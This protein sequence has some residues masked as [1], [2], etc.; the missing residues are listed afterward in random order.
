MFVPFAAENHHIL[1]NYPKVYSAYLN[2]RRTK[3][4]SLRALEFE[5][6]QEENLI[7]LI[8]EL[9][10]G[11][12]Q[13]STS[14]CFYTRK[15]KYREIFAAAFRDRIVHHLVYNEIAPVWEKIFIH[16]SY[17]C[18]PQKG[19]HAA[20]L[21]LQKFI[22]QATEN[23][24]KRCYYL[25]LDIKN[26]FMTINHQRL[27][28]ILAGKCKNHDLLKLLKLIVF[29][30]PTKNFELQDRE[31]IKQFIPEH[32]SLF[33]NKSGSGLPIGNLTS[34]FFAN[35]YLNVLDQF[36]KHKLKC[37]FY[38]RY[39]D[40]FL[41]IDRNS[42]KL[43]DWYICV[44]EFLKENLDLLLN[45]KATRLAPVSGG[46]DFVGFIVRKD[47]LLV[48][49]R[50]IG[51]LK[52]KLKDAENKL[53][54]RSGDKTLFY[55]N[56]EVI[57]HLLAAINSYL[58]HFRYAK[59][60][61]CIN[62][63]FEEFSFL[64]TYYLLNSQKI[65]RIDHLLYRVR[66]FKNQ[67]YWLNSKFNQYICLIEIGSYYEAFNRN[68]LLLSKL[69]GIKLNRNWRGFYFGCGFPKQTLINVLKQLNYQRKSILMVNQSG[70]QLYKTKERLPYLI[71]QHTGDN[72]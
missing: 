42:G 18:R 61:N 1:F 62:N 10:E 38:I 8:D 49:K 71:I 60:F 12:Y 50:V 53:V 17:A 48:R 52:E 72:L 56:N 9:R 3:R 46:I 45:E 2:C 40:D 19:T 64:K 4:N 14:V 66:S 5:V 59:T 34:Q 30:D 36:I 57:D 11:R 69:T 28:D 22:R 55:F 20:A 58:G 15:P 43:N 37:R 67:V 6:N 24:F 31:N 7:T 21:A 70:R 13:P 35:V 25:K 63:I 27:F 23:G 44:K 39:V 51:N 41:L 16:H 68:A 65:T 32:K 26:Y 33:K 47:Y 29:H 54:F